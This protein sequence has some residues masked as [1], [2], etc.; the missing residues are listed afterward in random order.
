VMKGCRLGAVVAVGPLCGLAASVLMLATLAWPSP[1]LAAASFFL[2]GGGPVLWVISS[3]T[4][5]QAIT[6]ASLIGRVSAVIMTAT[7]GARPIGALIGAGLG[8]VAGAPY[9]LALAVLAFAAQAAIIL[10]S[11]V[12]QLREMPRGPYQ[13]ST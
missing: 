11:P 3:T 2:M 8:A 6:P 4:L 7:W 9:C 13:V 5:R 12:F 10:R 1:W